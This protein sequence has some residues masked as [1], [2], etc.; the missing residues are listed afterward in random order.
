[1]NYFCLILTLGMSWGITLLFPGLLPGLAVQL[2]YVFSA[3]AIGEYILPL[4][5]HLSAETYELNQRVEEHLPILEDTWIARV[6]RSVRIFVLDEDSPI[7]TWVGS[8]TLL[9]SRGCYNLRDSEFCC[10]F[11]EA[12]EQRVS[13]RSFML[14]SATIGNFFF[15]SCRVFCRI[16]RM[17]L[18]GIGGI[19]GFILG[20]ARAHSGRIGA[21]I[22][23]WLY[24]VISFVFMLFSHIS[25]FIPF[26][27]AVFPADW[28]I[29]RRLRRKNL[30]G[31]LIRLI[32]E[33]RET[34][35]TGRYFREW[36]LIMR[37]PAAWR[38]R[39]VS[40]ESDVTGDGFSVLPGNR[41]S[42]RPNRIRAGSDGRIQ[43]PDALQYSERSNSRKREERPDMATGHE[44]Q[45]VRIVKITHRKNAR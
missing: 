45:K 24:R 14:L 34:R 19:I 30:T 27:L 36:G 21:T 41:R 1:M 11:Q 31:T 40:H 26:A 7:M 8:R 25:V 2:I 20:S 12:W 23:D 33:I 6:P 13:L 5:S 3:A 16:G 10:A 32:H 35:Y 4:L 38:L 18:M 37:P 42:R 28:H 15:L 43:I 29:D 44:E 17:I 39:W 9:V 22:G